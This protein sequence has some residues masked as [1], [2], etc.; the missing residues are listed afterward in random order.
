MDRRSFKLSHVSESRHN[1]ELLDLLLTLGEHAL[2]DFG[3]TIP[4]G[5]DFRHEGDLA[6]RLLCNDPGPT[7]D[8]GGNG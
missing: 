4:S 5:G 7:L 1:F 3:T 8:A 2:S 6:R